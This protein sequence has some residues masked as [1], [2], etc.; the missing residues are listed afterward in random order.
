MAGVSPANGLP[1]GQELERDD[2]ERV[3]IAR[4]GRRLAASL[5]RREVTGRPEHGAGRRECVGPAGRRDAEV[6]DMNVAFVVEEEVRRLHVPVDDAVLVRPVDRHRNL[7]E[8]GERRLARDPRVPHALVHGA[9]LEVLHDDERPPAMLGDVEDGHDIR[10]SREPSGGERLPS[11]A[12]SGVRLGSR[13]GR[14]AA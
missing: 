3:E 2:A 14:R 10:R 12:R 4:G 7:L 13:S 11:E 5:L 6:G 9:T 8:P 1:S